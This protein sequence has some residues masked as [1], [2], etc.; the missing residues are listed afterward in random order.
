MSSGLLDFPGTS[1]TFTDCEWQPREPRRTFKRLAQAPASLM[2]RPFRFKFGRGFLEFDEQPPRRLM[3]VIERIVSFGSL[4]PNW[5][6]YRARPVDP[7]CAVAAITFVLNNVRE[8]SSLP[9][10]VPTNRGGIQLEWHTN[11]VDL[12][13]EFS[14]PSRIRVSFDDGRTGATEEHVIRGDLRPVTPFL[15]RLSDANP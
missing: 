1:E 2:S 9:S 3:P 12:E 15:Q 8:P 5:D 10:A 11:G 6:S 7:L 14:S 13:I 4:Q